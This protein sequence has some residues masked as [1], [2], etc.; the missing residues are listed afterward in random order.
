MIRNGY[1]ITLKKGQSLNDYIAQLRWEMQQQAIAIATQL[2]AQD[3]EKLWDAKLIDRC[4]YEQS[5]FDFALARV[6]ERLAGV[7]NGM[8]CD[9]RYDLRSTINIVQIEPTSITVLYNTSNK[10]MKEYF[11]NIQDVSSYKY[12]GDEIEEDITEEENNARGL[13]WQEQYEKCNWKT[14]ML[15]LSA[16]I[17]LQPV[18]DNN[19]VTPAS[20][21]EY[22]RT[23]EDRMKEYIESR[24]VV[25]KVR[26]LLGNV[27]IEKVAPLALEE[28]FKEGYT[29]LNTEAG[30]REY[31]KIKEKIDCG[32][33]SVDISAITLS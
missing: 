32:F 21:R 3:V 18:L 13:F 30:Q 31:K 12:Y 27:P 6:N 10:K 17:T 14:A 33:I 1:K 22:F 16:Q 29:Y 8:F 4:E 7:A 5:I 15:G 11:E 23:N 2:V 24:I 26:L 25:D 9:S 19:N 28:M 20:L